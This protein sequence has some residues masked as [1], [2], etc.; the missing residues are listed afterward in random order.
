MEAAAHRAAVTVTP[1]RPRAD[2]AAQLVAG[3]QE[4]DAHPPLGEDRRRSQAG[5]AATDDDRVLTSRTLG[6][7]LGPMQ[8]RGAVPAGR[9]G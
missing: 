9:G 5:D 2:P 7:W 6:S 3:L 8:D 4:S 1:D